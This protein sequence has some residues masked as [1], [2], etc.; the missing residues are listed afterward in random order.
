V[1][2]SAVHKFASYLMIGAAYLALAL[3]RE[4]SLPVLALTTAGIVLSWFAE[5][6]RIALLRRPA[7]A[8]AWNVVTLI[9]FGLA[10]LEAVRG[11]VLA[12]GVRFLCLLVVNKLWNRRA[13]RDYLQAYVISFLMLVAGAALS[14]DVTYALCFLLYTIAATWTLTLFHLRREMEENYL[15]KHSEGA[16]SERVEVERIL[17]SRRIVGGSF[18][19]ATALVSLG[20]FLSS[21]VL[22]FLIPRVGFGLFAS[23]K[24]RGVSTV[25]FS[26]RVELGEYGLVKDNPTVIM[27]VELPGGPP[28]GPL[29]MRGVSFDRYARGQW[30]RTAKVPAEGHR[31][32]GELTL[33]GKWAG[34]GPKDRPKPAEVEA[35]IN[36]A[37]RQ[38]VYLEP[39]DTAVLFGATQPIA[40]RVPQPAAARHTLEVDVR[41]A[42]EVIA[43]E[44][45]VEPGTLRTY[46]VERKNGIRYSVWSDERMPNPVALASLADRPPDATV[47][48]E[49]APYLALPAELP[50]RIGALAEQIA[51]T[52]RGPYS[53]AVAIERHLQA[54]YRYTLDL[55]RDDRFEPLEDFLFVQ[56]AGHCE[57]FASA[58]AVMLRTL[59]IPSRT[60]NGFYGGEWN[61]YGNY[62]AIRQ[63][64]AH[65]WVEAWFDGVGWVTFDPTPAGAGGPPVRGFGEVLRQLFDTV[66]LAW[67]KWVIEYDLGKQAEAITSLRKWAGG[68]EDRASVWSLL[69]SKRTLGVGAGL[70][71]LGVFVAAMRRRR[72]GGPR[73]VRPAQ[74][75]RAQRAFERAARALEARGYT[76][77]DGETAKE[78]ARR[79]SDGADPGAAAFDRLVALYYAARFGGA[80]VPTA[81]LDRLADEVIR[82]RPIDPAQAAQ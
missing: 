22:F 30:S 26:E 48:P 34:S 62:L 2:F 19:G 38:D 51:Q 42:G 53:K 11:E 20:V 77:S 35:Q 40:F 43:V 32:W 41:G 75:E 25:G 76:R 18:L 47:P 46:S 82:A 28:P 6:Q 71:G 69:T 57:Y 55:K 68:G 56:R 70:L 61:P 31:R 80:E 24:R 52:A 39:L 15:V 4:L 17:N 49:L 37:R 66:E 16:H 72:R 10:V 65:T 58:M 45:H 5:P 3:S 78:L 64:D 60:V 81:D 27:R 9:G 13:S 33:I 67:F 23:S 79:V 74:G 73:L 21:T 14:A 50:R 36:R 1:R 63:G 29:R 12:S 7:W 8:T 44:R 54:S 59:G